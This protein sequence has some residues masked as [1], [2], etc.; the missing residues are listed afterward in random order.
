MSHDKT[1]AGLE[2]ETKAGF[3]G[4]I[5]GISVRSRTCG[6]LGLAGGRFTQEN[7]CVDSGEF[8]RPEESHLNKSDVL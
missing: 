3:Y 5:G 7:I 6:I 4:Y 2:W 1:V 8:R